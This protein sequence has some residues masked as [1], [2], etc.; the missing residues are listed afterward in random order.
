MHVMRA[1]WLLLAQVCAS[2]SGQTKKAKGPQQLQ[3]RQPNIVL[4]LSD[5]QGFADVSLNPEHKP[6]VGASSL[7]APA[8]AVTVALF[9]S[10]LSTAPPT[11]PL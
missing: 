1:R 3:Q 7:G 10:L 11:P 4:L 6:E 9:Q 8:S 2:W 5:D